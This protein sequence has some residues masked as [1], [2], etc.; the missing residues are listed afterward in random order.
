MNGQDLFGLYINTIST[1]LKQ[2]VIEQL[3]AQFTFWGC[4]SK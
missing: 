3:L 2:F 4:C 1:L